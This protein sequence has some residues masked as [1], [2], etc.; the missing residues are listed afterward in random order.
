MAAKAVGQ[1]DDTPPAPEVAQAGK[2]LYFVAMPIET[3]RAISDAAAKRGQTFA[4]GL[5]KA[6]EDYLGGTPGPKLL[7][8]E[9]RA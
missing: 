6:I 5:G 4:Q 1:P 3:Y 8:E 9:K 2:D 7:N